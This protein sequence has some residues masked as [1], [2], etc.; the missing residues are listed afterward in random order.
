MPKGYSQESSADYGHYSDDPETENKSNDGILKKVIGAFTILITAAFFI[1]TT[2]AA[3]ISLNS[4]STVEFGQGILKTTACSGNTA[5]TVKPASSF[6]NSAGSGSYYIASIKVSNIPD[7][8][9]G[10]DFQLNAYGET[11]SAPLALFNSTSI[12]AIIYDNAGTFQLGA[13][14]TGM[15]IA[16]GSGEFTITFTTPLALSGNVSRVTIQS[17]PHGAFSCTLGGDCIVG[18]VGPGGGKVFYVAAGGFTCGPLRNATCR[19]ME[20]APT[21]WNGGTDPQRPWAQSTPVDYTSTVITLTANL[22]YGA[23]NTK[24]IIDQ[25]NS[26]PATS[27]AALAAS[28]SPVVNGNTVNDWFLASENEWLQVWNQRTVIGFTASSPGPNYWTST[29]PG[30]QNGR[31]FMFEGSTGPGQGSGFVKSTSNVYVRPVRAF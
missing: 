29:S 4:A 15:T 7:S 11:S 24:A 21:N 12:D 16:S 14:S 6:T 27:A 22:G 28:Y 13:G 26:N 2:L 25:G 18:D 30:N 3:N 20:I 31:Y 9:F 17:S 8:C 23:Q 1:N 19:Y 10:S 5:L